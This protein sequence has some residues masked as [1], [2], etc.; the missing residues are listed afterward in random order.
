LIER[1]SQLSGEVDKTQRR[2]FAKLRVFEFHFVLA[3]DG[4]DKLRAGMAAFI[5]VPKE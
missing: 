5:T 3:L 1:S 2:H 4:R